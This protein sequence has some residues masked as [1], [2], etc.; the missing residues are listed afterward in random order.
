[1]DW[2]NEKYPCIDDDTDGGKGQHVSKFTSASDSLSH[3]VV[4]STVASIEEFDLVLIEFNVGDS[5][6]GKDLPHALEDKGTA[7]SLF[8]EFSTYIVDVCRLYEYAR[9]GW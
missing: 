6:V 4:W 9:I 5:F 8:G 1:M 7:A 3:F 2:L